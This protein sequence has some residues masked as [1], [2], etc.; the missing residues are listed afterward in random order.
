MGEKVKI[1]A[2]CL[3]WHVNMKVE[4]SVFELWMFL[5]SVLLAELSTFLAPQ[6]LYTQRHLGD[7]LTKRV[8]NECG[9]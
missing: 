3:P 9:K 2:G 8:P 4:S 1:Y 6:L 7:A 5:S